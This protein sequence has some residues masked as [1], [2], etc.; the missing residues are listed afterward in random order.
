MRWQ[1]LA[2]PLVLGFVVGCGSSDPK[3]QP[4]A[5]VT[6]AEVPEAV[7]NSARQQLPDVEFHQAWKKASGSYEVSGTTANGRVR[8]IEIKADGTVVEVQ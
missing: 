8:E 4:K 5:P 3:P 1:L 6:I 2:F 7:M